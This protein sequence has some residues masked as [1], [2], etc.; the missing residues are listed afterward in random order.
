M[1]NLDFGNQQ[2]GTPDS[3]VGMSHDVHKAMGALS[4]LQKGQ[5]VFWGPIKPG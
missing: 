3:A 1:G 2:L 4:V 5:G